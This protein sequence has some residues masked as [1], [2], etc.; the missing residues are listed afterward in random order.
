MRVEKRE[1]IKLHRELVKEYKVRYGTDFSVSTS[2]TGITK[3]LI[4]C[5]KNQNLSVLDCG[6]GSGILLEDLVNRYNTTTGIDISVEM[7]SIMDP[8]IKE[9]VTNLI[10][11]ENFLD[12]RFWIW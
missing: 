6:C 11:G 10:V 5:L 7:I 9:K 8:S 3:F 4:I 1:E 2:V 12:K